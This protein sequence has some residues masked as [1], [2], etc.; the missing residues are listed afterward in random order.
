MS[1]SR[2]LFPR[3]RPDY[4]AIFGEV[5]GTV[6]P[7]RVLLAG[8]QGSGFLVASAFRT[9][10]FRSFG[11][12]ECGHVILC[13][14]RAQIRRTQATVLGTPWCLHACTACVCVCVCLLVLVLVHSFIHSLIHSFVCPSVRSFILTW[15][16]TYCMH[17]YTYTLLHI[18][19][20]I[21]VHLYVDC[22]HIRMHINLYTEL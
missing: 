14:A 8:I 7:V 10:G 12:R 9:H 6:A 20:H 3:P 19:I 22:R 13:A 18:H 21:C 11:F 5:L 2:H 17:L 4:C 15:T 1:P 16:Y